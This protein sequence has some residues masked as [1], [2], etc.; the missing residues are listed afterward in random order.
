LLEGQ[1]FSRNQTKRSLQMALF[2]I[3]LA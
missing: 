1:P 3:L 2:S